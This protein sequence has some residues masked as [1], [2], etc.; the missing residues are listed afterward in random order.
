MGG[1]L[2]ECAADSPNLVAIREVVPAQSHS[3]SGAAETDRTWTFA[4]LLD[5]AEGCAHYLLSQFDRGGQDHRLGSERSG[6]DDPAIRR[7]ARRNGS[8]DCQSGVGCGGTRVRPVAV[9]VPRALPH[10]KVPRAVTWQRWRSEAISIA[11][12]EVLAVNFERL[13]SSGSRLDGRA[14]RSAGSL[15][16][17]KAQI[18]YT[19][20]TTGVPKGA[21]LHHRGLVNNAD[22]GQP[23]R[24]IP[25]TGFGRLGHATVPHGR[26][27][28]PGS[29]CPPS[30]ECPSA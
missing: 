23:E 20:G 19:S 14:R 11:G 13:G 3:L 21:L 27:R 12:E 5:E 18:Q 25:R 8:G 4:Q 9:P 26:M 24:S 6:V 16:R 17:D 2:R 10:R 7:R 29:R 1:L 15:S 28:H 22:F 30:E